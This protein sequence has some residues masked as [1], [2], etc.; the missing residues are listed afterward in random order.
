MS[1]FQ[2]RDNE[3]DITLG[4]FV[5]SARFVSVSIVWN[6]IHTSIPESLIDQRFL[7]IKY[8]TDLLDVEPLMGQNQDLSL[9]IPRDL[10]GG[11]CNRWWRTHQMQ[12]FHWGCGQI[13]ANNSQTVIDKFFFIRIPCTYERRY[14]IA[15][16]LLSVAVAPS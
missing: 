3:F 16:T 6:T 8:I 10:V 15:A 11:Y 7:E 13:V 1:L 14:N 4:E 9:H 5:L 2:Q 12:F